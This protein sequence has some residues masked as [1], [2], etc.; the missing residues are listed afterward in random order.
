MRSVKK[1]LG[2]AMVGLFAFVP[3]L[4]VSAQ[5]EWTLKDWETENGDYGSVTAVD[6]NITNIKGNETAT[7]GMF[8]GPVSK[9]V[10]L[11]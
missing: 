4:N 6:D 11:N 10:I 1:V 8:Y 5:T 2:M 9:K 3:F 7:G